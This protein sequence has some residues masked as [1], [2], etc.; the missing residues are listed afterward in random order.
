MKKKENITHQIQ[1]INPEASDP[2]KIEVKENSNKSDFGELNKINVNSIINSIN[3]IKDDPESTNENN[4]REDKVNN[5]N[6]V[7]LGGKPFY[8]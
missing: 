4:N 1:K 6:K 7:R 8:I 5:N 3:V 2:N